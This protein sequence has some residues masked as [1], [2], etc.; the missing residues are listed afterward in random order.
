M[1]ET[2]PPQKKNRQLI[3]LEKQDIKIKILHTLMF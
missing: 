1:A 2:I 3:I